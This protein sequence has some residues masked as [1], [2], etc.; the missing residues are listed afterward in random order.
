ML[1]PVI[2]INDFDSI[3]G[4]VSASLINLDY[5]KTY[6]FEFSN[7][8]FNVLNGRISTN[9]P[10]LEKIEQ[11]SQVDFS[12]NVK[13]DEDKFLFCKIYEWDLDMWK[14]VHIS[15]AVVS[16]QKIISVDSNLIQIEQPY[17]GPN[18]KIS[19]I[20]KAESEHRY[21][22]RI[23]KKTFG[24]K[25]DKNGVGKLLVNTIN[26]VDYPTYIGKFVKKI[27]CSLIDTVKKEAISSAEC[28]YVPENL[29]A[30][31][32]TNDPNRPSC[33]ILDPDPVAVFSVNTDA[34]NAQC[35]PQP[36]VGSAFTTSGSNFANTTRLDNSY[37]N[38]NDGYVSSAKTVVDSSCKIYH[39]PRMAR[40]APAVS[41]E[42]DLR[43]TSLYGSGSS[44]IN[45][46][47]WSSRPIGFVYSSCD[48][49]ANSE[50]VSVDPCSFTSQEIKKIPRIFLGCTTDATN[51]KIFGL[52]RG[53]LKAPPAYFHSILV[54]DPSVVSGEFE[55]G[56]IVNVVFDLP[57]GERISKSLE[58]QL[59]TYSSL[60]AFI[61]AF[62]SEISSDENITNAGI[63]VRVYTDKYRIDVYS[64]T[65]FN[66]YAGQVNY[67]DS[68]TG[69]YKTNNKIYIIRD[70]KYTFDFEI[71]SPVNY[72]DIKTLLSSGATHMLFLDSQFKGM[73]VSITQSEDKGTI[74]LDTCPR[75]AQTS[76]SGLGAF[77]V[78][79]DT[80]CVHVALI[81][82]SRV[83]DDDDGT[84]ITALPFVRNSF[85]EVI[86]S[87][88]PVITKFG[89]VFCQ[90]LID[91]KWQIFSYFPSLSD[92]PWLQ[93]TYNGENRNVSAC[94][95]SFGNV[96]LSWETDR[97]GYTSVQ[98]SC[99]GPS[100]KLINRLSLSGM[101][102]KQFVD[103]LYE[104][105]FTINPL[106][107]AINFV[108]QSS[109]NISLIPETS[110]ISLVEG[111]QIGG[112]SFS[113]AR[114]FT[115]YVRIEK[116][117]FNALITENPSTKLGFVLW[118]LKVEPKVNLGDYCTSYLVHFEQVGT[119][120]GETLN[121][122]FSAKFNGKILRVFASPTDFG[123]SS[124]YFRSNRI[125]YPSN[126]SVTFDN[127][128]LVESGSISVGSDE[129]TLD[130]SF[131]YIDGSGT[132]PLEFRVLVEGVKNQSSIE[133]SN[134][135]RIFSNN[136]RVSV[137]EDTA[138]CVECA[139][140]SDCA[141]ATLSVS[142][143]HNGT[144]FQGQEAEINISAH[145]LC[146]IGPKS[147]DKISPIG[148]GI[149]DVFESDYMDL[150]E[151]TGGYGSSWDLISQPIHYVSEF[152]GEPGFTQTRQYA[153]KYKDQSNS[154]IV[155]F[156][157]NDNRYFPGFFNNSKVQSFTVSINAGVLVGNVVRD[158]FFQHPILALYID[159]TD[160]DSTDLSL[161]NGS[162][163]RANLLP[164]QGVKIAV[165]KSR[166]TI[167]VSMPADIEVDFSIRVVVSSEQFD[168]PFE[169]KD[170]KKIHGLYS[171][172][173]NGFVK[174]SDDSYLL[175]NNKFTISS[176]DKRYDEI[177]PLL[178][179]L[180]Y[181][182]I[183]INP[184]AY[185]ANFNN[186][187]SIVYNVDD[188]DTT[189]C[190]DLV[191]QG[192]YRLDDQFNLDGDD[193]HVHHA[194]VCVIPERVSF[195]AR[196][197]ETLDEYVLRTK[198][199][200]GY[201]EA[202]VK[203]VYTGYGK[204]FIINNSIYSSSKRTSISLG[205]TTKI[206]DLPS[207]DLSGSFRVQVDGNYSRLSEED[208]KL[209][210]NWSY[211]SSDVF[212]P[213]SKSHPNYHFMCNVYINDK[214][215]L[216][217]NAQVDLGDKTRQW[218]V[219]F[220]SPFGQYPVCRS[221]DAS[222][223]DL[224][225]NKNWSIDYSDIRIGNP[226][227]I[228]DPR[229]TDAS[230]I[231]VS[232]VFISK[233]VPNSDSNVQN[234]SF[235]QS[236][237]DP[238]D[239][240]S[241]EHGSLLIDGWETFNGGAVYVGSYT[242]YTPSKRSVLLESCMIYND[243][244]PVSYASYPQY[245][246]RRGRISTGQYGGI[247]QT[248]GTLKPNEMHQISLTTGIRQ[249]QESY[250]KLQR[251]ILVQADTSVFTC[252]H[253]PGVG[254]FVGPNSQLDYK[255]FRSSFIPSSSSF[256][257]HIR[258][259]SENLNNLF[260]Y[261]P[262]NTVDYTESYGI[263]PFT[264]HEQGALTKDV[265]F[266]VDASGVL[267]L[268]QSYS[269]AGGLTVDEVELSDP[270]EIVA[271]DSRI[272]YTS[273][274]SQNPFCVAV[275]YSGFLQSFTYDGT[276]DNIPNFV[277][278]SNLPSAQGFVSVSLGYD[279]ACALKSDGTVVCW[280]SNTYGQT[281][282]P[283]GYK[284]VQV[285]AGQ[286]FTIGINESGDIIAW[287]RN[288]HAQVSPVPSGKFVKIDAGAEHAVG[289]KFD[290]TAV[291]WGRNANTGDLVDP[292]VKLIDVAACGG[293][294]YSLSTYSGSSSS[295]SSMGTYNVEPFN[296]GI[297]INGNVIKWGMWNDAFTASGREKYHAVPSVPC[298]A[299]KH[300]IKSCLL[301]GIDGRV[302][303]HGI[304]F[305]PSEPGDAS[306]INSVYK[307]DL[308]FASGGPFIE[309]V[310]S[311]AE[312]DLIEED[313]DVEA[314][315]LFGMG[316]SDA[317]KQSY[318]LPLLNSFSSIPLS[319]QYGDLQK[320]PSCEVDKFN[321]CTLIWE[322]N[323]Q[324]VWGICE[325]SNI[326]INRSFSDRIFLSDKEVPSLRPSI[327][328]DGAG[329][330]AVVWESISGDSHAIRMASHIKHPDYASDCDVDK[331]VSNSRLLGVDPDPYDPYNVEQSLM[332]CKV[333]LSFTAPEFGNYFFSIAFKDLSD[334]NIIYKQSSSKTESGKWLIN[335]KFISYDGQVIAQGETVTVSYVPDSNDNVF[336]KVLKVELT[337]S[338]EE[339]S[340]ESMLFYASKSTQVTPGV[341]WWM[342]DPFPVTVGY[343]VLINGS[344]RIPYLSEY[345]VFAEAAKNCPV[346]ILPQGAGYFE[347]QGVGKD[348][349]FIFPSGVSSL[350]GVTA[351][352]FVKSFL[353]VLGDDDG[354][355]L[356]PVEATLSF[357][358]P[359]VAVLIDEE[360]M[361]FS[362]GYFTDPLAPIN[363]S[364]KNVVDT[365]QFYDGEYMRLDEDRKKLHIRFYQ[366]RKATWPTPLTK[367]SPKAPKGFVTA[368]PTGTDTA[369]VAINPVP[370][371]SINLGKDE[372]SI[373]SFSEETLG[374]LVSI[375]NMKPYATFR[376]IVAN[377]GRVSGQ[378]VTTYFCP[379]P[380][381]ALCKISTSYT[382]NS[383][384]SK[385]VHFKV[386]VYSDSSYKDAIMAFNSKTDARLWSSGSNVFPVNGI[387]ISPS[388]TGSVSFAPP[389]IN[390]QNGQYPIDESSVNTQT[391]ASSIYDYYNL[392]RTSLICGTKYYIIAEATVNNDDIELYRT[393]FVCGCNDNLFDREDESEWRSVMNSSINTVIASAKWYIGNP[394]V[395]AT[396]NGLFAISWEDSRSSA[397][398]NGLNNKENQ[399]LDIY[400]GF[401]D[402]IND[403]VDSA[404]HAGIDR[405]LLNN[406]VADDVAIRDQRLP[407][408]ISDPFGNF[409]MFASKDYNKIIK[410]YF[411]VGSK[412]TPNIIVESAITT[413]CSF[414]LTDINTYQTAFDGGEFMQ[415][416]VNDKFIK[417]YKSIAAAAPAPIVN[418]CFVDLEIIGIPGAM[419]YR[420]KNESESDFT[421]WIPIN[422]PLQP[423]DSAGKAISLDASVFRETFKGRWIANDIFTAPWVLSKADGVKRVC[424]EILTQFGKTQQFCMDIIAEY[425]SLSYIVEIFYSPIDSNSKL[426]KP[427]RYKGIP[428]VNRKTYYSQATD[429]QSAVT[430]SKEDLRSLD[431]DSYTEVDVYVQVTFEDAE[432]IARLDALNSISSYA[433]RRK[434]NGSM[435]LSLY[436]QGNRVQT[437]SLVVSDA[438][439]GIYYGK[440]KINKNN[441]VTDKDGLAFVF[442]DLPSECLNPFVKN[443]ISVLRL[444]NDQNLDMSQAKVVDSNAFIEQYIQNDKRN[445]FGKRRIN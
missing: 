239:W 280:G 257:V 276:E 317:F 330:R 405:L 197:N 426:F 63:S 262:L 203:D 301:L 268:Y 275:T 170:D 70:S 65:K 136:G 312:S 375:E 209:L 332:S 79:E 210:S 401:F 154:P 402:A 372:A 231:N 4:L 255:T 393:S 399:N 19:V 432:R 142:Q 356:N 273:E 270:L 149:Q 363:V 245:K 349:N 285:K 25:T 47:A 114:E 123:S 212:Y 322:D 38:C 59:S 82:D 247:N 109:A 303:A 425:A 278:Q 99:I 130:F 420:I 252:R 60:A 283:S 96:H 164:D 328:S 281:A 235:A 18:D 41:S 64:D 437:A 234:E 21:D 323:S 192:T 366:P 98:Y 37:I 112:G 269:D 159:Q 307:T 97:Y 244:S 229:I 72:D 189:T 32:A 104:K 186:L 226:R 50:N 344:A 119:N 230:G 118:G 336:N 414:T 223:L 412:I 26:A 218:E 386:S 163:N 411:S 14:E 198:S 254:E 338:T 127:N 46:S 418:D 200:A 394:S 422:L 92:S 204:V 361:Q 341:T 222:F 135:N 80:N 139:P 187:T 251:S 157:D 173:L 272:K 13:N 176:T 377:T 240:V 10:D 359:I 91:N 11:R 289:I 29:Y 271:V 353:F 36:L 264:P 435:Q 225:S 413:A 431:L 52:A 66:I 150:I 373:V 106:E 169:I 217:H 199:I 33:V 165:N 365:F 5:K 259:V 311:Y 360:N 439:N 409:T 424:I 260:S 290:G 233:L 201:R 300:G 77:V 193:A 310:Y 205:I 73:T 304:A 35:F 195:M 320:S 140:S 215:I 141:V 419:A 100:S 430:I 125:S 342:N 352:T 316:S 95:D 407:Q 331:V 308:D 162:A 438:V 288:N 295:S 309:S 385:D 15:T 236:L 315:R 172:F 318:G 335:G 12:F 274:T 379:A 76:R 370:T 389:I 378:I 69:N 398:L 340:G 243:S 49:N 364:R 293:N 184:N 146:S 348:Q 327:A 90:A 376:V 23:D 62:A 396:R 167:K 314:Y 214:P 287:G 22:V 53:I 267:K 256:D 211:P 131:S 219:G 88:N 116:D 78:S 188:I 351:G 347:T 415:I 443:F 16:E 387:T 39:Q 128:G 40:I 171:D 221:S 246:S 57:S 277:N 84:K 89:H 406:S 333:D 334:V 224:M 155:S 434:D 56:D 258:N 31:A 208:K 71:T 324:G 220:G 428:V 242:A 151:R 122:L 113:I 354:T 440:F 381:R 126:S 102:S 305:G 329:R 191:S 403:S 74:V 1:S 266:Y 441:G 302:Y 297:D 279:H 28:E 445:A 177:I 284:F 44:P 144:Y 227:V 355:T 129:T 228:V 261:F 286:Y 253:T 156:E 180:K 380:L 110:L 429:S 427:V 319:W 20:I 55:D 292:T 213:S 61:T 117:D 326:W 7:I 145:A 120:T 134:W 58:Y 137:S 408:L 416:R 237:I 17:V 111:A 51:V 241:L 161:G 250:P 238:G 48:A 391:R 190:S 147:T 350:P 265:I 382:N 45:K 115:G 68:E 417:G 337:Y 357:N 121:S 143:D 148:L 42:A 436:Q 207:V 362:D 194:Y 24:I 54:G 433:S 232:S 296:V 85:N 388:A 158:I 67:V 442:V 368:S 325:S 3:S 153:S 166:T 313:V 2:K 369:P 132:G 339:T 133:Q 343:P 248:A 395:S 263:D 105:T 101:I 160:L 392:A 94:S 103:E 444:I 6:K 282:V 34:F 216:S 182:D 107:S 294:M 152:S 397:N 168:Y 9:V 202:I 30:L 206:S 174:S 249:V 299:V 306:N 358:Q 178:G 345:M 175:A 83:S 384:Q 390:I 81:K 321:K 400:C 423:L 124:K 421:D 138:A 371:A 410:R 367:V 291:S 383:S 86:P 27:S 196:N 87:S 404:Y 346:T 93:L 8:N 179:F 108:Q 183:N 75:V 181:D 298:V 374:P 43:L 185:S